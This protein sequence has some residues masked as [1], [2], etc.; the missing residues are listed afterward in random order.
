MDTFV[1]YFCVQL[2]GR[3]DWERV[4][5]VV[6]CSSALASVSLDPPSSLINLCLFNK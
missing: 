4:V 6:R 5:R 1:L 3:E 2:L